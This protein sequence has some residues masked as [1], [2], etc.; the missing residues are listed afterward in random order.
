LEGNYFAL[1]T[2]YSITKRNKISFNFF[3]TAPEIRIVDEANHELRDRY[4]KTGSIMELTCIARPS[5][6]GSNVPHPVWRKN[7][8]ILPDHV[9]VYHSNGCV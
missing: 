7:G 4:Y 5:R 9:N 8:E 3:K 6:P 2:I 1:I